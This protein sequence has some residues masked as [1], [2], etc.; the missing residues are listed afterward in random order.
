MEVVGYGVDMDTTVNHAAAIDGGYPLAP[1]CEQ[2]LD[3]GALG[4]EGAVESFIAA[5]TALYSNEDQ[6][7]WARLG[8]PGEYARSF[9]DQL[10]PV[11]L[12]IIHASWRR[13]QIEDHVLI[14][15]RAQQYGPEQA[16][17]YALLMIGIRDLSQQAGATRQFN[18]LHALEVDDNGDPVSLDLSTDDLYRGNLALLRYAV[19]V[20]DAWHDAQRKLFMRVSGD[21]DALVIEPRMRELIWKHQDQLD[22]IIQKVIERKEQDVDRLSADLES[23]RLTS[24]IIPLRNGLL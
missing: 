14:K 24:P 20:T 11:T 8:A 4:A 2:Y 22:T 16:R 10:D 23:G 1:I 7:G 9:A 19:A 18:G 5:V 15:I 17:N 12:N 13:G 3:R 21:N 6:D